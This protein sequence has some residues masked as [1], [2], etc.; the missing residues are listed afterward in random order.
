[1]A[2]SKP[3][4]AISY[5]TEA[6]L[7]SALERLTEAKLLRHWAYIKH[8]GETDENSDSVHDKDHIH[9]LMIPNKCIDLSD[10]ETEFREIIIGE[11]LPRAIVGL[12]QCNSIEDWVLYVE[13]DEEYLAMKGEVRQYAYKLDDIVSDSPMNVREWHRVALKTCFE[14]PRKL[15]KL[16]KIGALEALRTGLYGMNQACQLYA[17]D[18][19]KNPS[20]KGGRFNNALVV[21]EETGEILADNR[22]KNVSRET[23]DI[24]ERQTKPVNMIPKKPKKQPPKS[25]DDEGWQQTDIDWD[26]L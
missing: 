14:S 9:L 20:S 10:L 6:Y 12:K 4:T 23:S 24:V 5:N 16:E 21:D 11:E 7:K 25:D 8:K 18:R 3:Q 26:K 19:L 17:Y 1:M 13:H 2:T 22:R 15:Q